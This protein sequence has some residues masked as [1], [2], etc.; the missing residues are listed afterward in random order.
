MVF[1]SFYWNNKITSLFF[2]CLVYVKVF[3]TSNT[4]H[5][6]SFIPRV[7]DLSTTQLILKDEF[8]KT[9]TTIEI[10]TETTLNGYKHIL[11]DYDFKEDDKGE[12]KVLSNDYV[13]YRGV[14]YVTSQEPQENEISKDTYSYVGE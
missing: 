10:D 6:L 13:I 4:T 3:I 14:Y 8:Y 1:F 2:F 5:T 12:I 7:Y 9:E 11:F